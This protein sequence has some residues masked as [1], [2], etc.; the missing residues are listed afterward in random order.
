MEFIE[1]SAFAKARK[2]FLS[3]E[4]F[5]ALQNA[6]IDET[7]RIDYMS[8][9]GGLLKARW[10]REGTGKRGGLRVIYYHLER[11][12]IYL[13]LLLY[14]KSRQDDLTAGQKRILRQLVET[15]IKRWERSHG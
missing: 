13:L 14:P 2:R 8:G 12:D 15:E 4:S 11:F 1:S 5:R 10:S 6:L 3:D 7:T 9:T